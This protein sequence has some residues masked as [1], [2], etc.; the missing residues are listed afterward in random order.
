MTER[1]LPDKA[2]DLIDELSS[3][4][5]MYKSPAAKHAKD[6][7]GQLKTARQNRSLAQE[8]GNPDDI[9]EW[10]DRETALGEQIEKLRSGWDRANMKT[11][12]F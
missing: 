6:L 4:V 3:R 2:I 9:K 12:G 10:E 8:E 7:F 11:S 1:F 5:R